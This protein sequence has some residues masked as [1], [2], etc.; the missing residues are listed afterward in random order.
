MPPDATTRGLDAGTKAEVR[1]AQA[2]FWEGYYVRRGVDL[3]HRFGF[4][5]SSVTDLDVLGYS[6][7]SS[8]KHQKFIGEVKTGKANNTPRPL[9]R[10]LW[11]RGLRELVGAAGGEVTTAFKTSA[12]VRDA[13]RGLGVTVQHLDD[14]AAR[15]N[16]LDIEQFD[17]FGSQGDT[18]ALLRRDVQN[19]VKKDGALERGYWFLVSEVWFLEPFDALKRTLGL[20]RELGKIWPP[21]SH[22]DAIAVARWFF[23][24]AISVVTLNLAIIAG[25]ANS[26]DANAFQDTANSRLASG[27]A[28]IYAVRKLSERFDEYLAKILTSIDAPPDILTTAMGAFMPVPP[29]YSAPLLELISRM[30]DD[31]ATTALLPRQLDAVLFERLVR[32]RDLS[33]ELSRRLHLSSRTQRLVKLI[34]AFLRGQFT[35]P[36]PVDKVLTTSLQAGPNASNVDAQPA[37]AESHAPDAQP[38]STLFEQDLGNAAKDSGSVE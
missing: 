14:L 6:F 19:F 31:A 5:V 22:T 15:E 37:E 38:Q 23:A 36:G 13:C 26:M 35:L 27:D 1:V 2:W 32:R 8:L 20:I 18:I 29:D 17:D 7:D 28:P 24:E 25:E 12:A 30:A 16:R 9:D 34:A 4:E 21:E 33:P 3:Q 11:M 10:A